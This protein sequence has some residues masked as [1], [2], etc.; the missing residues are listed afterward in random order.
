[1]DPPVIWNDLPAEYRDEA[2]K[3][4]GIPSLCAT[5]TDRLW[6]TWY[7]GGRTEDGQNYVLL[8]TSGDHGQTWSKPLFAIDPP[9]DVRAFDPSIWQDPD[10]KLWLFWAQGESVPP[11]I[12]KATIWDGRVGV[13]CICTENPQDGENAKWS[14]PR[15]LCDGIMMCKPIVDSKN[16]WLFPVAIWHF[17]SK[18]RSSVP[19]GANV[20]VSTDKGKTFSFLGGAKAPF[21]DSIFPEHNLI[22]KKDGSLW[23]LARMRYGIGE[24]VSKDGGKTFPDLV[25]S[26]NL[27][28][29][30]SR[31]FICR[32]NSGNLLLVKNGPAD[33]DVG[34]SRM[35]AHL[36]TDD[37]KTWTSSLLLDERGGVSYPDGAQTA[38]GTI[39]IVYDWGRYSEK[40]ICVA[41]FTEE[42]IKAGKIVSDKS[43]LKI[44]ANKA[45]GKLEKKKPAE[46]KKPAAKK[47]S[48]SQ[49][50]DPNVW[51][52]EYEKRISDTIARRKAQKKDFAKDVQFTKPDYIVFIP[53]V[54]PEKLGDC[55][56]DHFQVFENSKGEMFALTCQATCEGAQD[57]HVAFFRSSD[58]GKTWSDP[59][60]LAGPKTLNDPIPIA[61][62]AFPMVSRSDR[63][64]V[65]FDQYVPGKVSTNR[66]HTGIMAGI[67]SDDNGKTWSQPQQV[68]MP[69]SC[70]DSSDSS[71][72]PEWVVWQKPLR[73]AK[74][75]KYLVGVSRH[76]ASEFHQRFR[77]ITQF[78]RFENIDDD[79]SPEK[80]K[81]T[82][83]L[84]NEKALSIGVHC[85]EPSI[86]KLPDGRLFAQMRTGTGSPVWSVSSDDGENWSTPK[87]LL[88]KNGKPF[89]HPMSPCPLYDWKG[90]NAASGYYFS[91]IHNTYNFSEKSPWQNRG[92]LYLIAGRYQADADQP[93]QFEE[94]RLFVNRKFN[95]S[96]YTSTTR[97]DGKTVLWYNDQKFYLLGKIIDASWFEPEK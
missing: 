70:F 78:I 47:K 51:K 10:G 26:A 75:N 36:S 57:Q 11:Q 72:P 87:K 73:L 40:E 79:P 42:D 88:D 5:G 37:G 25:P 77:T 71:I 67:F 48:Y 62:W 74:G 96:F 22:E 4:Q 68:P 60:V 41:R 39:S 85:E 13:W 56:N 23:L 76:V 21:K 44:V 92:P 66:Q 91:F 50:S 20:F 53:K 30:S 52:K 83:L 94:P 86:V 2:R 82:W 1:M 97:I 3:F 89:L 18:Y 8:I 45:F 16:R 43:R 61:S 64:Y 33:K 55:Y 17:P 46:I 6:A 81:A 95:Q 38:D 93:I 28:N 80:I 65:I 54:E 32:L 15:R 59:K 69:R 27:K 9:G 31:F 7:A 58:R 24:S 35:T 84:L 14:K 49:S 12:S 90:E 63:I 34:R 19:I 29:T